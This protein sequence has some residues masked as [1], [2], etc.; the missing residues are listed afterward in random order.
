MSEI[1]GVI[2]SFGPKTCSY[3]RIFAR[4]IFVFLYCCE[5]WNPW[6]LIFCNYS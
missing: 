5:L 6:T 4:I 1:R 3:I 2:Y